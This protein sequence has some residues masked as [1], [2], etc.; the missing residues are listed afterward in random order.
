MY[1]PYLDLPE[2]KPYP[3]KPGFNVAFISTFAPDEPVEAVLEA[4]AQLPDVHFYITGNKAKMP[5]GF[6]ANA[7]A[8]VTFTGFLIPAA[9]TSA[10][11]A[12]RTRPSSSPRNY[13]LQLGGCEALA[14]GTPL[15][16]SD[17]PYLQELFTG[18]TVFAANTAEGIRQAVLQM[19]E[20]AAE[21][22]KEIEPF[23]AESRRLWDERMRQLQE[24]AAR[25]RSA[26][27]PP[28]TF[29]ATRHTRGHVIK[30]A[31]SRETSQCQR[32]AGM[33][34]EPQPKATSCADKPL[35]RGERY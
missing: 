34:G 30:S 2:G 35:T 13:T 14:V 25:R 18:G 20:Q 15:I 11:C 27:N 10:C 7:P 31:V 22:T 16:T 32:V 26:G 33:G 21:L 3:L 5:A 12:G 24:P 19:H 9:S 28:A 6:F 8:N 1:D 29:Q 23:R 17:W 4:A